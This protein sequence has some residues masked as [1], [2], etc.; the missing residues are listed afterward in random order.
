MILGNKLY[1][2]AA[3]IISDIWEHSATTVDFCYIAFGTCTSE[4]DLVS[5]DALVFRF[6]TIRKFTKSVRSDR[7]EMQFLA[8]ITIQILQLTAIKMT[9]FFSIMCLLTSANVWSESLHLDL[10]HLTKSRIVKN[11]NVLD[12][13]NNCTFAYRITITVT[14]TCYKYSSFLDADTYDC[15]TFC[16]R[17][18]RITSPLLFSW[19][20]SLS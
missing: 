1:K 6:F 19:K 13:E 7:Y 16:E 18:K 9:V 14:G 8:I 15:S 12:P 4:V 17:R 5:L 2:M 3:G 20:K 10:P 11:S